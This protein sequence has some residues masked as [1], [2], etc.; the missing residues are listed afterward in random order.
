MKIA[1]MKI[2]TAFR[3]GK[4][5]PLWVNIGAGYYIKWEPTKLDFAKDKEVEI[6]GHIGPDGKMV[7][8]EG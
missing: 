2:W 8:V 7:E 1:D 6:I 3:P 4:Y 5:Y